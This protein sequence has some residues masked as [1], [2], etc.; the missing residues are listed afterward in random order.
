ML[1]SATAL[2]YNGIY[3]G[4]HDVGY[5]YARVK[6]VIDSG[7]IVEITLLEH[8]HER[9]EAAEIITEKIIE[10]QELDVDAVAS[11]TNSSNVIKKAVENALQG[12]TK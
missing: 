12:V 2:I 1:G 5:I 8:R 9:G 11:A 10:Q 3:E 7:K 4:E 6:V